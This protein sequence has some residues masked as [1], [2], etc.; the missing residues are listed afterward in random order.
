MTLSTANSCLYECEVMHHRLA[1]REH[2]FSYKAFMFYIDLDELKVL[3]RKLK[4]FSAN[5][6]NWFSF[7]D[8]DHLK[9]PVASSEKQS[10][11][12]NVLNYLRDHG[13]EDSIGKI[14]LLTNV[15][16]FGH[17]F[18]PISFYLCFDKNDAPV[19]SVAEVC[20]THREMKLYL[21]DK[22]AQIDQSF[23]KKVSKHFYVSP[24]AELDSTFDFIFEIPAEKM[25][26]RVDDYQEGKRFLL[27][28]LTGERKKLTDSNLIKYGLRF[29]FITI[30]IVFLIYWHAFML[31]LKR[32][33][34]RK[35][36]FNLHLQRETFRS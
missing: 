34:H 23:R 25:H 21:L 31:M 3:H 32:V 33:P 5:R 26:M 10:V 4:L 22:G 12:Q 16:T 19:C 20:N 29:P 18:N 11:K 8:K 36:N 17:A 7:R 14:M 9:W 30:R 28:A 13:I 2:R 35:K 15:A 1:P 6:F 24:F 27:T